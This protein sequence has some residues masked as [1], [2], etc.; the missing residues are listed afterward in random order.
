MLN[1][2]KLNQTTIGQNRGG[3]VKRFFPDKDTYNIQQTNPTK[4]IMSSIL[5]SKLLLPNSN[6]NENLGEKDIAVIS[7]T[8]NKK[9]IFLATIFAISDL[10]FF[11]P[12]RVLSMDKKAQVLKISVGETMV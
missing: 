1:I 11:S 5:I 8:K 7:S 6:P 3:V 10:C 2:P 12:Q 9:A 4:K